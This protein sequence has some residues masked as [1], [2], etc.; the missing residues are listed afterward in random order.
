MTF[1]LSC[2]AP[3]S[4]REPLFAPTRFPEVLVTDQPR[5]ARPLPRAALPTRQERQEARALA[6]EYRAYSEAWYRALRA[7]EVEVPVVVR[8]SMNFAVFASGWEPISTL[9]EG[10]PDL[11][12]AL[13]TPMGELREV[14]VARAI[15]SMVTSPIPDRRAAGLLLERVRCDLQAPMS[16]LREDGHWGP[17]APRMAAYAVAALTLAVALG[18]VKAEAPLIYAQAVLRRADPPEI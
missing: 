11:P 8:P 10:G 12:T 18:D 4:C 15:S 1:A 14:E 13:L 2:P 9:G 7:W 16:L 5:R 17:R 6:H 3:E